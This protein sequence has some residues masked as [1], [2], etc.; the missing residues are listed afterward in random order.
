MDLGIEGRVALVCA[1]TGGLGLASARALAA[2]GCSVVV[3]GRR[4]AEVHRVAEEID[5]ATGFTVDV[6]DPIGVD[7]LCDFVESQI[8]PVDIL[9]LN[10]PGPAVGTAADLD[11]EILHKGL[12]TLLDG[13]IHLVRRTLPVMRAHGWGR[14]I[15]VGSSGVQHPIP[16]LVSSNLG[17]AALAAYLKTLA[18]EVA[19]D[20]ITVNM[21]LPG[22]ISTAR[23]ADLDDREAAR[24]GRSLEDVRR[25]SES[26]I[27]VGRYG[28]IEEF[29][30]VVAFLAGA[31]AS[32][33]TGSIVRCDGGMIGS[34]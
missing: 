10:G 16:N 31:V 30:S 5:G 8:G 32:Y 14:V 9:I 6:T 27:P 33:V 1:S 2:E 18:G 21:V 13:Q 12:R 15:A 7:I 20:G 11:G 28:S 23:V 24:T 19:A 4:S 29:G 22:R 17:R 34:L 25:A 26:R 3:T